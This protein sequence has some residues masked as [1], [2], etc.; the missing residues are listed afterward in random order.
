[1]TQ[2]ILQQFAY[3]NNDVTEIIIKCNHVDA[4]CRKRTSS[5][6]SAKCGSGN[7]ADY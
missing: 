3:N 1:M 7:I 5:P 2:D 6:E 4:K